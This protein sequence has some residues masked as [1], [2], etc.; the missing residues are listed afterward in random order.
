MPV[1]ITTTPIT[2]PSHVTELTGRGVVGATGHNWTSNSDPDPGETL[3]SN[4]G[5]YIAGVFD[6]VHD[7]G[8]RT[9]E[10]ASK[11]K[12]SLFAT[13][14]DATN[15]APDTTG[16]DNGRNKIDVYVNT[17]D[18]ADLVDT[19]VADMTAQPFQYVF[20]HLRDPDSVGHS[21]GWDVTPGSEYSNVIKTMDSRLGA[22]FSLIDSDPRLTSRTAVI[23][24]ADHGG[25]GN[26]HSNP[27]LPE[28]YTVPFY[29]WGPGV[30]SGGDLYALNT[31]TRLNPGTNRPPYSDP[32][33][34]IRNGEAA[35]VALRL[36]G[37][38]AVPGSIIDHAQ[39]LALT[40]PAPWDLRLT[41][42]GTDAVL[43]FTTVSNLLYDVQSRDD[44]VSGSW[45]DIATDIAGTGGIVTNLETGAATLPQRFYRVRVHF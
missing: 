36:L 43:T 44:L 28:D 19:L 45:G 8:L 23:L 5:S 18:T 39:D 4:K 24:T 17:D 34:P 13:S 42:V 35:N 41:L 26:D 6:V 21:D 3:A 16:D 11:S 29:V 37:L 10:Y 38:E 14:W 33:Q 9:G 32:L 27:T 31:S 1:R 2:L 40:I 12:F 7:N 30:I 25:K 15:G 20:A 22:I